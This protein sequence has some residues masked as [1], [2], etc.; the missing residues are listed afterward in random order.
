MNREGFCGFE[1]HPL[2]VLDS[3]VAAYKK[4]D[5]SFNMKYAILETE[6]IQEIQALID[7][8]KVEV[9]KDF[10]KDVLGEEA[11][12]EH[13]QPAS[14]TMKL[15]NDDNH[16]AEQNQGTEGSKS[17]KVWEITFLK[18]DESFSSNELN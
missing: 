8:D 2:K 3:A 17:E 14:D 11:S 16:R 18:D 10:G 6:Y 13:P 1:D 9:S 4:S 5:L 7:N 15:K 12:T